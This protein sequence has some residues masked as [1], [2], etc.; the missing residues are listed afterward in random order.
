MLLRLR[1][2]ANQLSQNS[3]E[4]QGPSQNPSQVKAE[5]DE[6]F[7]LSVL[8][9][10]PRFVQAGY[11]FFGSLKDKGK[12]RG[13][14]GSKRGGAPP[15]AHG[16]STDANLRSHQSEDIQT[17]T[18]VQVSIP[19]PP[20][21]HG[22]ENTPPSDNLSSAQPETISQPPPRLDIIDDKDVPIA[23]GDIS[24]NASNP[25]SNS[26]WAPEYQNSVPMSDLDMDVNSLMNWISSTDM[27]ALQT[28]SDPS[29]SLFPLYATTVPGPILNG[30][31]PHVSFNFNSGDSPEGIQDASDPSYGESRAWLNQTFGAAGAQ[32]VGNMLNYVPASSGYGICGGVGGKQ[33]LEG[34]G[35]KGKRTLRAVLGKLVIILRSDLA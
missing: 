33:R 3:S 15:W 31:A 6:D 26:F 27:G 25:S 10:T 18:A 2:R 1:E 22:S 19:T 11:P 4:V 20:L 24:S 17:E 30:P 21:S 12:C 23:M 28:T 16:L 35:T 29:M 7:E 34:D 8:R 14:A 5:E 13:G 9:G 32:D